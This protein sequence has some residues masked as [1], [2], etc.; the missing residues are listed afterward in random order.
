MKLDGFTI[1]PVQNLSFLAKGW[2]LISQI[3]KIL[4]MLFN[5]FVAQQ[6]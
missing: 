6:V 3:V 5:K 1:A 2:W 4:N